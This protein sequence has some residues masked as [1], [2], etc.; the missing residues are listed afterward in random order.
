VIHC[1]IYIC[2]YNISFSLIPL[3]PSS[4]N[5][6]RFHSSIFIY[7]YKIHPPHTTSFT[8]FLCPHSSHFPVF[9]TA[10]KDLFYPPFIF[11]FLSVCGEF[12]WVLQDCMY[13]ALI[14]LTPFLITYSFPNTMLP[15]IQQLTVQYF[16]LYSYVEELLHSLTFFPSLP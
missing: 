6:N 1:D 8:L 4:N 7:E 2:I 9:S 13:C 3:L 11:L 12:A 5:S 15:N 14:K 10:G 16:I